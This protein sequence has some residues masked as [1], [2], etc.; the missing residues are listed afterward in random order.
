MAKR[1]SNAAVA[2]PPASPNG[3]LSQPLLLRPEARL[4]PQESGMIA[5]ALVAHQECYASEELTENIL[6][7]GVMEP[8]VLTGTQ[9]YT[10]VDGRRR[11]KIAKIAQFE[12]IPFVFYKS[13]ED[14]HAAVA[15]LSFSYLRS[16]NL[17]AEIESLEA[18]LG[19]H[20]TEAQ[21]SKAIGVP[22]KHVQKRMQLVKLH[23]SLR[24]GLLDGSIPSTVALKACTFTQDEQE[25]LVEIYEDKEKLTWV[26]LAT[27][28]PP[29]GKGSQQELPLEQNALQ[30]AASVLVGYLDECRGKF[31]ED[32]SSRVG[33]IFNSVACFAE[34]LADAELGQDAATKMR[35]AV[36]KFRAAYGAGASA[37][38]A[39]GLEGG[40][41][42]PDEMTFD[43]EFEPG[44]V[45][46]VIRPQGA[47]MNRVTFS[48]PVGEAGSVTENVHS[49]KIGKD[50]ESW[51]K[52]RA[53]SLVKAYAESGAAGG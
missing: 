33:N 10:I 43:F 22:I 39:N 44:Q 36:E 50:A 8:V 23:G 13:L 24:S 30:L 37:S 11:V 29:K 12:E 18:L 45:V 46:A 26:D 48:G 53:E 1:N 25:Q 21:I 19:R 15:S 7:F 32:V 47:G 49:R 5:L 35:E 6:A 9:P 52:A 42:D 4:A 17:F 51:A 34:E 3:S 27:V 20:S 41:D 16:E 38:G 2:D 31:G 14:A 28:R 40:E